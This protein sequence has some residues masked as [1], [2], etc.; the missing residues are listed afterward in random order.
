M[1]PKKN[2]DNEN[3]SVLILPALATIV[4]LFY[5]HKDRIMMDKIAG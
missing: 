1:F 3:F 4:S 2:P 5:T